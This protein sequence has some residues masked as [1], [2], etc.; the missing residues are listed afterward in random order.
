MTFKT[1]NIVAPRQIFYSVLDNFLAEDVNKSTSDK[2]D[3]S[4]L[5]FMAMN[6]FH[7]QPHIK[8]LPIQCST[9]LKG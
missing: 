9:T 7:T 3:K 1:C 6:L 4:T 8:Q 2:T 5:S